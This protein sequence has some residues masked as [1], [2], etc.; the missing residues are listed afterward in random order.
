MRNMYEHFLFYILS[1][2]FSILLMW[3]CASTPP[4][5]SAQEPKMEVIATSIA[6][7]VIKKQDFS[8]P[9]FET[10]SFSPED[11]QA[12][13]WVKLKDISGIH[14]LKW[15]WYDPK[16]NLYSSSGDYLINRDSKLRRSSTSWHKIAIRG[17]KASTLSGKWV[18]KVFLD[19]M[20]IAVKEFEIKGAITTPP[21]PVEAKLPPLRYDAYAVIIGIDYRSRDDISHLKYS[22]EDAKK[23]YDIFTDPK[24]GGIPKENATLLLNEKATRVNMLSALR[25]IKNIDGYIYVYYSGHGAPKM[26]E[27][28]AV[29]AYLVPYD[30]SI[31]DPEIMEDT[32]ITISYLQDIIKKSKSKGVMVAIDACFSGGGEKSITVK[33]G[34]PLVGMFA[35]GLIEQ[36][37]PEKVIITSSAMEEQSWEDDTEIK[38]GIFSNYLIEGLKGK[39]GKKAWVTV[40]ELTDYI[41]D[42]VI[43]T[44]RKLK[45]V[46][47]NPQ[48]SGKGAFAITRNWERGVAIESAKEK[49]RTAFSNK[50]ITLDQLNKTMEELDSGAYSK[51]L[52]LFL[53][54]KIDEKAFGMLY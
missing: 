17:E 15:E 5:P 27:D 43:R 24:Y 2:V 47:Q 8:V 36:A 42:N 34:K 23:I 30:V 31:K 45:G 53:E 50:V 52:D 39:A 11:S 10:N 40:G 14:T 32:S 51:T 1:P 21:P 38:G 35:P 9:V 41:K 18:A 22:S 6:M 4:E 37:D 13:M 7:D 44:A 54:G 49:L 29:D 46:A 12:V 28:K 19:R 25:S 16:G 3:G 20:P 26:K 48:V 33:G